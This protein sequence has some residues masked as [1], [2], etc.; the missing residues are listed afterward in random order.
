MVRTRPPERRTRL[1]DRDQAG[2]GKACVPDG[3]VARLLEYA[4]VPLEITLE[5][6]A[7]VERLPHHHGD[8]FDRMLV[9]KAQIEGA[10]IVS[11]DPRFEP[12]GVPVLW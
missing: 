3:Y 10:A 8:P 5:H 12:Y 1:G 7:A 2:V 6:A 11:R 4:F 9:A